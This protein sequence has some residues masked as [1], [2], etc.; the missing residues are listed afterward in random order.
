MRTTADRSNDLWTAPYDRLPARRERSPCGDR[1]P[2]LDRDRFS[3]P[4][5]LPR[6]ATP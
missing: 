5:Q 6:Q 1:D 2:T 4:Q 3:S